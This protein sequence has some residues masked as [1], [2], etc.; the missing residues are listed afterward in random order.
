[1][2]FSTKSEK[3]RKKTHT[4]NALVPCTFALC[5]FANYASRLSAVEKTCDVLLYGWLTVWLR[6]SSQLVTKHPSLS[7]NLYSTY[8]LNGI[9]LNRK[10]PLS[11]H[12][13]NFSASSA[14]IFLI[15]IF[16][17]QFIFEFCPATASVRTGGKEFQMNAN[18]CTA[19]FS[20]LFFWVQSFYWPILKILFRLFPQCSE[21][22]SHFIVY[23][24]LCMANAMWNDFSIRMQEIPFRS[25]FKK[26]MF[27]WILSAQRK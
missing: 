21:G 8:I 16:I 17:K 10:F 11:A 9:L 1:M 5:R 13:C 22:I 24:F 3:R 18:F 25:Y 2:S 4:Q 14:S 23:L 26:K 12:Y 15:S 20:A 7:S 19:R 27:E 6:C